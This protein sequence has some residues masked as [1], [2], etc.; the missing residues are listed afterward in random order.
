[1]TFVDRVAIVTGASG[2]IGLTM[3]LELVRRGAKVGL[4]ARREDE[5]RSLRD[6]IRAGGG[7]AEYAV[8]DLSDRT[9]TLAAIASLRAALGPI[10]L[11]IANAGVGSSNVPSDLKM[12]EADR[13]IRT[14]LLGVMYSIEAVLPEMLQRKTGTIAGISSVASYKGLPGAAAY[15]ASKAGANAYLESLRITYLSSGVRFATICP[16]FIATPMTSTNEGM[17]LVIS[18]ENAAR[19]IVDAIARGKKVYN[20]PWLTYRLMRLTYWLPDWVIARTVSKA[21]GGA[22]DQQLG[23]K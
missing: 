14:N 19:R 1:M 4:V 5:L 23:K 21:V 12:T 15:C 2:G 13:V 3:A 18:P 7:T 8:A 10:D 22:S 6:R 17:F 20:F 16:G 9:A 11:L